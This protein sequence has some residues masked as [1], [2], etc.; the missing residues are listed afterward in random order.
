MTEIPHLCVCICTYRRNELLQRTL[1]SLQ[2]QDTGGL[3][4]YSVVVVDN[5]A[6]KCA[7]GLVSKFA[8]E[9]GVPTVYC[10]EPEQNIALARNQAVKHSSGDFVVFIDDDEF[11][12]PTWLQTLYKACLHYGVDGA[13]GPVLP[14]FDHEPPRWVVKGRFYNRPSYP[15]GLIIDWQKGRTGNTFLKRTLFEG[16][17]QPFNPVFITGED[18]DF[19]RRMIAKGHRFVWCDEA[20]AY[21]VVPPS[22][23]KRRFMMRRA[24]LR[25]K[26]RTNHPNSGIADT[27]KSIVAVGCYAVMLPFLFLLGHHLFINHLLKICDH[28]GKLLTLAGV[29]LAED[30][31]ASE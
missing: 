23:C 13:L 7:E 10:V 4:S 1:E 28:G 27:A 17:D 19:F 9:S 11:A 30:K 24:F 18:Q 20:K 29:R 22:R 3:F 15:T 5:D 25:G 31:Y 21:E 12:P 6:A 26:I 8:E 16:L 2:R 14:H